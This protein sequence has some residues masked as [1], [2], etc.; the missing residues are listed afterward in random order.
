MSEKRYLIYNKPRGEITARSDANRKTVMDS[1]PEQYRDLFP[2]GRLDKET[3]GLLLFTDDGPLCQRLLHPDTHVEKTYLFYSFGVLSAEDLRRLESGVPLEGLGVISA[4]ARL[5]ILRVCPLSE[6]G[7]ELSEYEKKRYRR[8]WDD[9]VTVGTLTVTEG[10]KHQV[11]K[12]LLAV[13]GR[14][15]LLRRI[16]FG[17]L[18]LGDLP[19]GAIRPLTK[20]ERTAILS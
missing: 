14:V 19:L 20:G 2:V 9:P 16:A 3:E 5:S 10:K 8:H 1:I 17:P 13:G 4:P 11:R 18:S 15:M 12:M 7:E 6:I